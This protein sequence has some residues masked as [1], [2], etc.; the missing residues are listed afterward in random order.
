MGKV[1]SRK[2]KLK[3]S[4]KSGKMDVEEIR[5]NRIE[6]L[7]MMIYNEDYVNEAIKK[8]ANSLTHGLMK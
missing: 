8:L 1:K 6:N 3:M 4:M 7:K 2:L 5:R